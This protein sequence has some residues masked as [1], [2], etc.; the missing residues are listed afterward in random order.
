[1]LVNAF[2]AGAM[3]GAH[4]IERRISIADDRPTAAAGVVATV[5]AVGKRPSAEMARV[6]PVDKQ[7]H[8]D[9]V[10][11]VAA[12][13]P[14][15]VMP[16]V[17][18]PAA[19]TRAGAPGIIADTYDAAKASRPVSNLVAIIPDDGRSS[20]AISS[21]AAKHP[22][23]VDPASYLAKKHVQPA[24]RGPVRRIARAARRPIGRLVGLLF[25]RRR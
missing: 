14:L 5:G 25:H 12:N 19:V 6:E 17:A 15:R 2:L 7:H 18:P 13:K 16:A 3:Y 20:S 8:S 4:S 22:P 23:A 10:M 9:A 1:M 24:G 11:L 21:S